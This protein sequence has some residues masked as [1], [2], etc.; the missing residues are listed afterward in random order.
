DV[1]SSV[2]RCSSISLKGI[3]SGKLLEV[4]TYIPFSTGSSGVPKG[5]GLGFSKDATQVAAT[6]ASTAKETQS[7][8]ASDVTAEKAA[9]A[10]A[11]IGSSVSSLLSGKSHTATVAGIGSGAVKGNL[12]G[13]IV[14]AAKTGAVDSFDNE[15]LSIYEAL[16]LAEGTVDETAVQAMYEAM[17]SDG[18][19]VS[20]DPEHMKDILA[21]ALASRNMNVENYYDIIRSCMNAEGTMDSLKYQLLSGMIS[22]T[23]QYQGVLN[24][25]TGETMQLMGNRDNAYW[26]SV[27]EE[28]KYVTAYNDLLVGYSTAK[29]NG[30]DDIIKMYE[31]AFGPEIV[32]SLQDDF[33]EAMSIKGV[34]VDN[35]SGSSSNNAPGVVSTDESEPLLPPYIMVDGGGMLN[36]DGTPYLG[37]EPELP[38]DTVIDGDEPILP[39]DVTPD[40]G[41]EPELPPEV[42]IDGAEPV[43]PPNV[44]P[45][46]G[47]EPELPPEVVID[48][49]EPILPPNVMPDGGGV[50][51]TPA[52]SAVATNTSILTAY[53]NDTLLPNLK[54]K[55]PSLSSKIDAIKDNVILE[56]HD[57]FIKNAGINNNVLGFIDANNKIRVDV[58]ASGANDTLLHESLHFIS[59][60]HGLDFNGT[61]VSKR[62]IM[63]T[64]G[65]GGYLYGD[66]D[67]LRGLNETITEYFTEKVAGNISTSG[68]TAAVSRLKSFMEIGSFN[69]VPLNESVLEK[70]FFSSNL[71]NISPLLQAFE[72]AYDVAMGGYDGG[73]EIIA[74]LFN[75]AIQSDSSALQ[76][77]DII[78]AKA[79][80]NSIK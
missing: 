37:P 39:P 63:V 6:G 36:P 72:D 70:A 50:N 40:L 21:Q 54:Q 15:R 35:L 56:S 13:D 24:F 76:E 8:L 46:L 23:V 33:K 2:A 55:Y 32:K 45:D 14:A 49:A 80:M 62:G 17:L 30:Y 53:M 9:S 51:P 69:G 59:I 34:N 47:P 3:D 48:G 75:K 1:A 7:A 57:A 77:L 58:D 78:I 44:T 12:A 41:P 25:G 68:Y 38:P 28:Q 52:V 18:S 79:R 66:L 22:S 16:G 27:S 71:D 42:V 4:N 20:K 5:P 19:F 26:D 11:T 64:D 31:S 29:A 61:P 65:N 60:T 67:G 74:N 73:F 43:L 10:G